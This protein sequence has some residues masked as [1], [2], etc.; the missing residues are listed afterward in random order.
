[1]SRKQFTLGKQRVLVAALALGTS[2]IA[3]ADDSSMNPF[4]GDSYAYFNGGQNFPYGKPVLDSSPSTSHPTQPQ[5][6]LSFQQQHFP[7]KLVVDNAPSTF[8][9][10]PPHDRLPSIYGMMPSETS[11]RA[12]T[13]E[14]DVATS[15]TN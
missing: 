6:A 9:A 4:T 7:F 12:A 13:N 14:A 1:M 5:D 3:L 11:A 2:G 15:L 8:R 10:R